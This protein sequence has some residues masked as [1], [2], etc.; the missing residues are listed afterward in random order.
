MLRQMLAEAR[1]EGGGLVDGGF[2]GDTFKDMLDSAL[3]DAMS[4]AGGV[5]I[6]KMLAKPL[7]IDPKE[8]GGPQIAARPDPAGPDAALT[9]ATFAHPDLANGEPPTDRP[10][11]M[12]VHGRLSSG[13]GD[14]IDP[15]THT[16]IPHP[17]LD[18]A[19][20]EGTEV[21]AAAAG[22]VVR[23]GAAGTYGNLVVIRHPNGLETRYAHLSAVT[24]KEGDHVD[25][26]DPVGLVGH[27]GRATGPHLHFEV[28][29]DGVA[30]DPRPEL[31]L[32]PPLNSVP[33]RTN[34]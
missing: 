9:R 21:D 4:K 19:A 23:A 33:A 15:I 13:F 5:G 1:T 3:S 30:M 11:A 12:P 8:L 14:R 32:D 29:R 10:F 16:H 34:R 27:T 17:G 18:I 20:R 31:N 22:K 28:R 2:A 26:G 25:T 6:A 24:V 7:G